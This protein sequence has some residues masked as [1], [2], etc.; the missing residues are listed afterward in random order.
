MTAQADK[1]VPLSQDELATI[2]KFLPAG[3]TILGGIHAS[4]GG[5]VA[6]TGGDCVTVIYA[7]DNHGIRKCQVCGSGT[8]YE[9]KD[10]HQVGT[11]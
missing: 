2:A 7:D 5:S 10:D 4:G 8:D 9:I 3:S 1:P 11:W 6:F